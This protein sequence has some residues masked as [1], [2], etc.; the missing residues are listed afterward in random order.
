MPSGCF[1]RRLFL[2][3]ISRSR[4]ASGFHETARTGENKGKTNEYIK[5]INRLRVIN[6]LIEEKGRGKEKFPLHPFKRKGE[7]KRR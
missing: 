4:V 3:S 7:G 6:S 2:F 5:V 1:A